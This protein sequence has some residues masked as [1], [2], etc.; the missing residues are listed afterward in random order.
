MSGGLHAK[1]VVARRDGR[2][3]VGEKHHR[4]SYF[5]LDLHHDKFAAIA[6]FAYA[7][8]CEM[9]EPELARDLRTI[10]TGLEARE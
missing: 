5:V 6:L 1:Y 4:C 7:T 3:A 9:E 2:S 10:V 8:A